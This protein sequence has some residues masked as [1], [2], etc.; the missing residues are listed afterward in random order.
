MRQLG[1]SR[2]RLFTLLLLVLMATA[3][4]VSCVFAVYGQSAVEDD[5]SELNSTG[6]II[7]YSEREFFLVPEY[8]VGG[9]LIVLVVCLGAFALYKKRPK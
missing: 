6:T 5:A 7:T 2:K 1:Q 9:S 8:D 3:I 4:T